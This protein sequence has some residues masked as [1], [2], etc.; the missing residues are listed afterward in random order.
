MG[1]KHLVSKARILITAGSICAGILFSVYWFSREALPS[2]L[3]FFLGSIA[4]DLGGGGYGTVYLDPYLAGRDLKDF[5]R[6]ALS[7]RYRGMPSGKLMAKWH[8][9][10]K[11]L[12]GGAMMLQGIFMLRAKKI[13]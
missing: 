4:A 11:S 2:S 6:R 9:T 10:G 3:Q 7:T 13:R 12:G 8:M 1:S 5:G